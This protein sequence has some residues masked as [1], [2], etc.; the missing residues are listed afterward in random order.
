MQQQLTD[1]SEQVAALSLCQP[2]IPQG[3]VGVRRCFI[4]NEVG[5]LQ[6]AC[7]TQETHDDALHATNLVMDGETAHRE[8]RKGRLYGGSSRPG[9]H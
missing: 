2:R 8:T 1:L 3:R 9:H 6:N 5:H 7:P 4:C